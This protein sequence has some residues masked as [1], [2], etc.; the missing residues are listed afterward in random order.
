MDKFDM[1]L[2]LLIERKRI[3]GDKEITL[4]EL[5]TILRNLDERYEYKMNQRNKYVE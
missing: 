5:I 2:D 4:S 3:H 1:L